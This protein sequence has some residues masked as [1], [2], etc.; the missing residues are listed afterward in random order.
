MQCHRFETEFRPI[1]GFIDEPKWTKII[2]SRRAHTQSKIK[3]NSPRK[4][5][6]NNETLNCCVQERFFT[7]SSFKLVFLITALLQGA[8]CSKTKRYATV[9]RRAMR[10]DRDRKNA[11]FLINRKWLKVDAPKN[12]E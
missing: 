4:K 6:V 3:T 12:K 11:L 2:H 7:I 10:R 8:P 9:E 5:M 1:W